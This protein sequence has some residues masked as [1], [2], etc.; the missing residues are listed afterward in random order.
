M[1]EFVTIPLECM[2][3]Q[4]FNKTFDFRDTCTFLIQL[5]NQFNRVYS[6][7]HIF[8]N[9]TFRNFTVVRGRGIFEVSSPPS[10]ASRYSRLILQESFSLVWFNN[11]A[12]WQTDAISVYHHLWP[13]P[14]AVF[15]KCIVYT[16]IKIF[17]YMENIKE[18]ECYWEALLMS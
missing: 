16:Y 5:L 13:W 11:Y 6:V 2:L 9:P 8:S 1:P 17:L 18:K 15:E 10:Q 3:K 12:N 7:L 14:V 4:T